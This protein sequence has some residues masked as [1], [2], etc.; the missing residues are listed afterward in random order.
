VAI[1]YQAGYT[2]TTGNSLTFVGYLAGYAGSTAIEN[3]GLGYRA[4]NA[5]T[6]DYNTAVGTNAGAAITSGAN[7]T[8]VGRSALQ[9]AT[10][11]SNNT[12]IG[13]R[14]LISTSTGATNTA[15]GSEALQANTTASNNTAVGYN[16]LGAVTT[17][18][19]NHALGYGAGSAI[20]TGGYNVTIGTEAGTNA[21]TGSSITT[22]QFNICIG[23]RPAVSANAAEY[24]I[25]I[26]GIIAGKGDNT[27]FIGGTSGAYNGKNVTTWETTSDQRIKKNIVDNTVGLEK[28]KQI[29]VRNF[30][31][32]KPEEIT[33]LPDHAAINK[34]GVQL[35]VIAQEIQQVLPEC[36]TENST[37]VLSVSTDP[38]VWHLINAVKEL[39]A[40]VEELKAKLGE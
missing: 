9:S 27:A 12:A 40:Q 26:G 1:G 6:G 32:R 35:G 29:R 7:N 17:G 23:H 10:T 37:G 4:L 19:S 24:Q 25:V 3:T 20:T 33:E 5:A 21:G 2:N 16:A 22:G 11:S 30:E 28:I 39:S 36:V 34:D 8:A 38:L 18:P 15:L 31:Y 13:F 14:A